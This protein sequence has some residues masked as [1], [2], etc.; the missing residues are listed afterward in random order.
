MY[1]ETLWDKIYDLYLDYCPN[2]LYN[3]IKVLNPLNWRRPIKFFFQ[4]RFRGFDDSETWNLDTSFYMWLLP[5]L[6]R[7]QE[8]NGCYP[9]N[10][11]SFEK[12]DNEL[13]EK[14]KQLEYIVNNVDDGDWKKVVEFQSEFMEWF[15]NNISDLWW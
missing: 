13:K 7:F 1:K 3:L 9:N 4:R 12:W 2:W 6:K 15:K 8:L 10:Y 14:I 11:E 5:R